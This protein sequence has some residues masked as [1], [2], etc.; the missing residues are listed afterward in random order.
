MQGPTLTPD[1]MERRMTPVKRQAAGIVEALAT[2]LAPPPVERLT[3]AELGALFETSED[4]VKSWGKRDRLPRWAKIRATQIGRERGPDVLLRVTGLLAGGAAAPAVPQDAR[5]GVAPTR[6]SETGPGGHGAF[7]IRSAAQ[8][9]LPISPDELERL[10]VLADR[11]A[12]TVQDTIVGNELGYTPATRH[13][14]A[15]SLEA[16]ASELDRQCGYTVTT[17]IWRVVAWLRKQS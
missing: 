4:A 14:L 12:R 6:V 17:D 13:M 11:I 16:F 7:G 3:Y 1:I 8:D 15:D 10:R 9:T 5:S 2:V